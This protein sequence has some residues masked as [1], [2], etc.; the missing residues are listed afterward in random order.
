MW[1]NCIENAYE[2]ISLHDCIANKIEFADNML[3]LSF[4]DGFWVLADSKYNP[5]GETLH[6]DESKLNFIDFDG[7]MSVCYIFK[8]H[9]L[10]RK[11]IC[12]TRKK[13][14]LEMLFEKVNVGEWEIEFNEQ[15]HSYRRKLFFGS[16]STKKKIWAFDFQLVIDCE[17][18]EYCWN[19]I[20]PDRKW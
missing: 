15:Y 11:R 12:T 17:N 3:E 5:Y 18:M 10:F 4:G 13:I 14:K 2:H 7:E 6:T 8:R 19:N 9:Y 1:K 16:V 20:C